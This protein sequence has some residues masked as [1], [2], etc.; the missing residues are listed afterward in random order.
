MKVF[1]V[2]PGAPGS[3]DVEYQGKILT[4]IRLNI[5]ASGFFSPYMGDVYKRFAEMS[6]KES[7]T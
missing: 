3:C 7:H 2:K 6:E 4:G 1:N 5:S